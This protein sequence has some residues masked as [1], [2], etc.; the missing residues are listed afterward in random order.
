MADLEARAPSSAAAAVAAA[1]TTA[2]LAALDWAPLFHR[3]TRYAF[4]ATRRRDL[5]RVED[6]AA[7]AIAQVYDHAYQAWDPDVHPDIFDHLV[8]VVRGLIS[9]QRRSRGRHAE[10]LRAP[11]EVPDAASIAEAPDAV[12]AR[13]LDARV[14]TRLDAQFALDPLALRIV[15]L[16]A[17]GV[18][19]PREQAAAAQAPIE[20][21]RNARKRVFRATH[22][23][24]R[25]LGAW[26]EGATH[27]A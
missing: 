14:R 26:E 15:A 8:N 22:D 25:E 4:V 11:D 1:R 20:D 24:A 5:A 6:L 17:E 27:A 19:T 18:S 10:I 13:E 16:L 12:L 9:N 21:I 2:L 3:L 23:V 7:E